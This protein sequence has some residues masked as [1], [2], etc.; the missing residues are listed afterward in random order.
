MRLG[1][2]VDVPWETVGSA[3]NAVEALG[4]SWSSLGLV[5]VVA[6]GFTE[7]GAGEVFKVAGGYRDLAAA[8][9]MSVDDRQLVG[10]ISKLVTANAVLQLIGRDEIGLDVSAN[11]YLA[12][13]RLADDG[14]TIRHL[15]THTG[16]VLSDFGH[17]VDVVHPLAEVLGS[18]VPVDFEPGSRLVYSNAGYAVLGEVAAQVI[19]LAVETVLEELVLKPLG[20]ARSRFELSWPDDVGPG[21]DVDDAAATPVPRAVP[22]VSAAGGLSSTTADLG[23]LVAGWETLLEPELA[24]EAGRVHASN[25]ARRQGFG[26]AIDETDGRR[27]LW[28]GGG[29][30]G[31]TASLQWDP[32]RHAVSTVVFNRQA[33]PGPLNSELLR[34]LP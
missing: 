22:C 30:R 34:S 8:C 25:G 20:M 6:A 33:N 10:S 7:D 18:V 1:K 26:W 15:L 13:V 29:V 3:D 32:D 4:R 9:P 28:H 19:G 21:Y 14:V 5:G 12:T 17:F 23:R 2:E 24:K 27:V 11:T 31:F 16:G